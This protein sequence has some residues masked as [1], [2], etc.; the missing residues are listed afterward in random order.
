MEKIAKDARRN[1]N[2]KGPTNAFTRTLR[3]WVLPFFLRVGV[4]SARRTYAYRVDWNEKVTA[5]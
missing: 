1:S 2:Q 5:T 3:D 4:K